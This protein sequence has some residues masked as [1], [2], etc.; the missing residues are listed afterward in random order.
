MAHI[1]NIKNKVI[2]EC[3]NKDVIKICI[4]DPLHYIVD[5]DLSKL[6]ET[7]KSTEP[8]KLYT[9]D[10]ELKKVPLSKMKLEDLKKTAEE[11]GLDS[12]GLNCD[13]LRKIIK[14]AQ[15]K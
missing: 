12:E 8:D 7:I 9:Q 2:T 14:D 4:K 13:E 15:G 11:L 6:K 10:D 5:D 3:L 1:Y